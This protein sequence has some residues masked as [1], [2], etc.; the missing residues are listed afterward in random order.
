M[1]S[2]HQVVPLLL[3]VALW[4]AAPAQ[5]QKSHEEQTEII[6]PPST[7][8]APNAPRPDLA[9]VSEQIIQLTNEFRRQEGRQEVKRNDQL[10]AAAQY[11]ADYMA[12]TDR[13]GH[14]ADGSEPWQRAKKFG[15]HYCILAE[16]I[17]DEF[18]SAGFQTEQLARAF[19]E[20]WKHSP[21]H[22]KNMLDPDVTDTGVAVAHSEKTGYYYA[23]QEFGRPASARIEFRISNRT[24]ETVRY[25]LGDRTFSLQPRYTRIHQQCRPTELTVLSP[26]QK[27]STEVVKK[28][29]PANGSRYVIKQGQDSR[30][31]VK[32]E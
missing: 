18:N 11:F 12:R 22:R 24:D 6:E 7:P 2:R 16:N 19:V 9:R 3:L 13:F 29:K 27:G 20:G 30:I 1:L 10:T 26:G 4:V 17:A 15:Y 23:V 5:A 25:K 21:P 31:Q 8:E 14:T 32:T 28:L